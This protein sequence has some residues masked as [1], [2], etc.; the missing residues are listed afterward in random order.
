MVDGENNFLHVAFSILDKGAS[1]KNK[2]T[3]VISKAS[4][5]TIMVGIVVFSL[6]SYSFERIREK[7]E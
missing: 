3:R 1:S 7:E 6:I 4:L 5:F 2:L